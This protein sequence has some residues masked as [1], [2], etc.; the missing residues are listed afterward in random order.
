MMFVI[1]KNVRTEMDGDRRFR[2]NTL[3]TVII[4]CMMFMVLESC[5]GEI[6]KSDFFS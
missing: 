1:R 6:E 2:F 5:A 3:L 4:I